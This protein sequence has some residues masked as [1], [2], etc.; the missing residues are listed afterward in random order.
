MIWAHLHW[1]Q[2]NEQNKAPCPHEAYIL[3]KE[4]TPSG[5]VAEQEGPKPTHPM[6]TRKTQPH[7]KPIKQAED[8]QKRL[9]T[10]NCREEATSSKRNNFSN[11]NRIPIVNVCNAEDL[12]DSDFN[13]ELSH[14]CN[15]E[16]LSQLK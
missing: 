10:L 5:K 12:I 11:H 3:V 16:S 15:Q 6:D 2:S 9:F 1:E 4:T 14:S 8:W 7:Q 13:L